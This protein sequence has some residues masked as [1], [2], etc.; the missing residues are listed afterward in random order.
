MLE[1]YANGQIEVFELMHWYRQRLA[2][3]V[4]SGLPAKWW[5]YGIYA[6]GTAIPHEHRQLYR[7]RADLQTQFPNPF[8]AGAGTFIGV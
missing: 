2:A 5:Y 7:E 8:N 4:V 3:H 1:R 6:D